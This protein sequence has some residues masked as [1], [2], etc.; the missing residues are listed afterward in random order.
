LG[1][2]AWIEADPHEHQ[3]VAVTLPTENPWFHI[4]VVFVRWKWLAVRP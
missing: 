2:G 3:V 1:N 4:P